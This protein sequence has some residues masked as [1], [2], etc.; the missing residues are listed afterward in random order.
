VSDA[1]KDVSRHCVFDS[2]FSAPDDSVR[3][4]ADVCAVSE[5]QVAFNRMIVNSS[6]ENSITFPFKTLRRILSLPHGS[7]AQDA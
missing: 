6:F 4:E 5:L 2:L 3:A 7:T 1:P